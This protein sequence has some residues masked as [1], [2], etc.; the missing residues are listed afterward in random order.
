MSSWDEIEGLLADYSQYT[1]FN[2]NYSK[3][4]TSYES[5]PKNNVNLKYVTSAD[6]LIWSYIPIPEF[7]YILKEKQ[8]KLL[9]FI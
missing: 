3:R 8:F 2:Y 6:G 5:I 7:D 1:T 9:K 4:W